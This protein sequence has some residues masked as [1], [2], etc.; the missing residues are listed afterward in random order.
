MKLV[1]NVKV[2]PFM[3]A[4]LVSLSCV[5]CSYND[6]PKQPSK[7]KLSI[8]TTIFPA[9]DFAVNMASEKADVIQLLKPGAESHTFEPTPQDMAAI[10]NCD[11]FIYAG[12]NSDTW[13]QDILDSLDSKEV[14]VIS[15]LDCVSALDEEQ[16]EGMQGEGGVL[17]YLLE[18]EEEE[19]EDEHVWTSPKNAVLICEKIQEALCEVDSPNADYYKSAGE[20][21]IKSLK[22]LDE[23]YEKK[24]A[25]CPNKTIVVADRFPFRYLVSEYGIDYY[26][27]FPGC[28]EDAEVTASTIITLCNKVKEEKIGTVFVIEFSNEKIADC[29]CEV[30]NAKIGHLNSCHN[31][32]AEQKSSG[33]S[34]ISIMEDNLNEL[35]NALSD[36]R[37]D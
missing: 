30:T 11:I 13:L 29:I 12:G 4:L 22:E 6:K 14:K 5:G 10:K 3:V 26:A 2:L 17:S 16:V 31:I 24:L 23:Q 18:E 33:A 36:E 19:E 9:Y 21:Y 34:Y 20:V 8:V 28:S 37:E 1:C 32:S 15:M 35:V 27:A 7:D 25:L